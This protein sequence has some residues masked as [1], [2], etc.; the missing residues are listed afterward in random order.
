M[1][2]AA[3]VVRA[4]SPCLGSVT[5]YPPPVEHGECSPAVGAVLDDTVPSS[6][7]SGA[8]VPA[9]ETL[10]EIGGPRDYFHVAERAQRRALRGITRPP[11]SAPTLLEVVRQIAGGAVPHGRANTS[12]APVEVESKGPLS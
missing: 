6:T 12:P 10:V 4:G 9:S 8:T 1:T 2:A 3:L 7:V 5:T 11:V